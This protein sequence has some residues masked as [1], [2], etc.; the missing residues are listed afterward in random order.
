MRLA[1]ATRNAPGMFSIPESETDPAAG[2]IW[3]VNITAP[4]PNGQ[5][6]VME[7]HHALNGALVVRVLQGTPQA[8]LHIV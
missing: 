5:E 4:L 3:K 1:W 2:E 7:I 8:E 6:V